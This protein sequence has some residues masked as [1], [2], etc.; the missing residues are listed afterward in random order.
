MIRATLP[1]FLGLAAGWLALALALPRDSFGQ[2]VA[3]RAVV[4][5]VALFAVHTLAALAARRHP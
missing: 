3:W 1:L 2:E 5:T 4:V